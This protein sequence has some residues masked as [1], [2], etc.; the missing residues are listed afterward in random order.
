M[1]PALPGFVSGIA[2]VFVFLPFFTV[3][4]YR[5]FVSTDAAVTDPKSIEI[6]FGY[7][8][9]ER[10][11]GE[12][13]FVTPKLALNYG[14]FRDVELVGEFALEKAAQ[15][16]AR[17]EDPA[18]SLKA[19]IKEGVLQEKNGVSLAVEAGPLLP[20]TKPEIWS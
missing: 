16:K 5:P 20:S 12:N 6:D 1:K 13:T 19:I 9:L 8:G 3:W 17:L 10:Q 2:S 11:R 18:V 4:A 7:F 14:L 15:G